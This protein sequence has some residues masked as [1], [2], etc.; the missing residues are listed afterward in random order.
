MRLIT[1]VVTELEEL[2]EIG[3][4]CFQLDTA[5]AFA[6]ASLIYRNDGC[7]QCLQPGRNAAGLAVG[8]PNQRPARTDTVIGDSDSTCIFRKQR[9]VRVLGVDGVELIERRI[10]EEARRELRPPC[11]GVE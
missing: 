2:F 3:V 8:G 4:P 11:P 6:F 9:H 5:R 10:Q 7:I 1:G